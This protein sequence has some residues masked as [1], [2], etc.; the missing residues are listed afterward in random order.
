VFQL[1]AGVLDEADQPSTVRRSS[2]DNMLGSP[3]ERPSVVTTRH[4]T[5]RVEDMPRWE[6]GS[7]DR[8]TKAALEL[9]EERGFENTSVV[10]IAERARVT[11]RTFFRYFPDKSEVLFAESDRIR[12]ALV[13]AI[14]DAPD[15]SE[16]LQVVTTILAEF[17][18][19]VPGIELQRR[20]HA[21]IA[22]SPGLLERDLIKQNDIAVEFIEA[23]RRRGVEENAARLATRVGIQVF[24]T[25]YAQWVERDGGADLRK[26]TDAAMDL[27]QALVPASR[28]VG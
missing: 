23:L 24:A 13:Q 10:E 7:A 20:R 3:G 18:W 25:A 1:F 14:L 17:D 8:L 16:P 27:L 28:A 19:S 6:Q 22:A 2:C 5:A 26:L 15:V 9:F 4:D 21:V 12:T 11:T